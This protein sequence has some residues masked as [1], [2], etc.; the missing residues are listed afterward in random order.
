MELEEALRRTIFIPHALP[1]RNTR[2]LV[3]IV[4]AHSLRQLNAQ[5]LR[6]Q[7]RQLGVTIPRKELDRIRCHLCCPSFLLD[8]FFPF[9]PV[10]FAFVPVSTIFG[11]NRGEE[12][13]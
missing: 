10:V 4:Q 11:F 13:E 3:R 1:N 12:R 7:F 2:F 8:P 5:P 6:N 9:L